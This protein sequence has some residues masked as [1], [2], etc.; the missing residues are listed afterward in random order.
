MEY[1]SQE[2]QQHDLAQ[3]STLCSSFKNFQQRPSDQHYRAI[4]FPINGTNPE[5]IWL[6][7]DGTRGD[8]QVTDAEL[9]QYV[10]GNV[11]DP[12]GS[13]ITV[14]RHHD[15]NREYKNFM[16][17]VHDQHMWDNCQ[18][19]NQCLIHTVGPVAQ[20]WYGGYVAHGY[21]YYE[22]YLHEI[23]DVDRELTKNGYPLIALDLDTTSL[24]PLIA[25]IAATPMVK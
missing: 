10:P 3:H 25:Y 12:H 4:Y 24:G 1:C 7:M 15:L 5:F 19:V 14:K 13:D 21:K 9:A 6:R 17:V 22:P 23:D 8:H 20:Y 11:S 18:P 2:C 16:V